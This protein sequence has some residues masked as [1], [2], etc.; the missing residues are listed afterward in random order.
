MLSEIYWPVLFLFLEKNINVNI[1]II[2]D[3]IKHQ[4]VLTTDILD[5]T[6]FSNIHNCTLFCKKIS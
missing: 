1:I 4:I 2:V 6:V 3:L 5:V